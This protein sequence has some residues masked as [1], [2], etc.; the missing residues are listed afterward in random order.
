MKKIGF[1]ALLL[2]WQVDSKAAVEAREA[3]PGRWAPVGSLHHYA[4][5]LEE[6]IRRDGRSFIEAVTRAHAETEAGR[7]ESAE[8]ILEEELGK[9]IPMSK[10][11]MQSS[12][13]LREE[14]FDVLFDKDSG[15]ARIPAAEEDLLIAC[16]L[17][18]KSAGLESPHSDT[19]S[20]RWIEDLE[21]FGGIPIDGGLVKMA[22]SGRLE[23]AR[24]LLSEIW[25]RAVTEGHV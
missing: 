8:H 13:G 5:F 24:R 1:L 17:L 7:L 12:V 23:E 22:E 21:R 15:D 6:A 20:T 11:V 3:G 2:L 4:E 14:A 18:I 16:E 9:V 19:E 25:R 10:R